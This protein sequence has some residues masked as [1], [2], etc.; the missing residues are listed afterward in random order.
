[1][2]IRIKL[3]IL[4]R[5]I[6]T[7]LAIFLVLSILAGVPFA[8]NNV[9]AP[10]VTNNTVI[11]RVNVT[12]T[13]PNI[14][15]VAVDD[16]TSN[17]AGQ[18]DLIANSVAVVTCNATVVDFNGANDINPNGTNATFFIQSVGVNANT[19]NNHLYINRS[20]GRCTEIST[21]STA[22]DCRI[23]L[24]YYANDS[25]TWLCNMSVKDKG[26]TA[27]S[28]TELNLT[29]FEVSSTTTVNKLLAMNMSTSLDYGNLTVTQT[30]SE[31]V[32]N[33]T[34]AGNINLNITLRGY[35][36]DN[37]SVGQNLTMI[38]GFGNITFGSQRYD[39]GSYKTGTTAFANMRNLT[40]QTLPA[41]FTFPPRVDDTDFGADRNSTLWRLQIPLSV[42]G[43]C[44]GTI[45]FGAID[46]EVI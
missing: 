24:Q 44:N 40:N 45:I 3:K 36:G 43:I 7:S 41:N 38:C 4:E 42:G 16:D 10:N 19:D 35:G 34:N 29:D 13:E 20:C 30:S 8:T 32:H 14:T 5:I 6:D 31:I 39:V 12:N 21:T 22:C 26:G 11:V 2:I 23:A 18:I 9:I 15:S 28:G 33:I 17:P 25:S 27:I 46:A 37:E 1:M